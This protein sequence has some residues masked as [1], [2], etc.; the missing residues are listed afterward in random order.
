M[1]SKRRG[2]QFTLIELL[3][4]IAII[5]ILAALLLPT[6]AKARDLS[7]RISCANKLKQ[8]GTGAY[9]YG[10]DFS[11]APP[12]GGYYY[13]VALPDFP[14]DIRWCY[15]VN[16]YLNN[17]KIFAC[18]SDT[19]TTPNPAWTSWPEVANYGYNAYANSDR[20]PGFLLR[21]QNVKRPAMTPIIQDMTGLNNF[22]GQSYSLPITDFQS[23][24]ARHSGSANILWFDGHVQWQPRTQTVQLPLSVGLDAFCKGLW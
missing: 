21:F 7:Q 4:V 19:K 14:T 1:N 11:D 2:K 16:K 8:L 23:M 12:Q 13:A 24:G 10:S 20:F 6:L 5:A 17:K 3:V 15:Q 18:P 9:L 22:I